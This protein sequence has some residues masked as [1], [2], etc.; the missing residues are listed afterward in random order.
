MD[1]RVRWRFTGGMELLRDV[2]LV[3]A[4]VAMGLF[5]GLFY[6]FS[7][8]VMVGLRRVDDRTFV[9]GMRGINV[10][11]LNGWFALSFAGAGVLTLAAG[12]LH[13][14]RSTLPWIVAGFVLYAAVLV[15]T[16]RVNVPLND[17]LDAAGLPDSAAEPAAI[18]ERFEDAWVRWNLVRTLAST[19]A[20]TC[21]AVAMRVS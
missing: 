18:R 13:L 2:S 20:L 4:T 3:S 19:G 9:A 17:A 10:G 1:R 6:A 21:L 11:I 5:A 14:G 7:C 8:A 16:F 12:A 15:I